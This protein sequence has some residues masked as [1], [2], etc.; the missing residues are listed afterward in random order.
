MTDDEIRD[1]ADANYYET[2][3]H[4]AL[5]GGGETYERDGIF[6]VASV[7]P[8]TMF[9]QAFVTR[10]LDDPRRALGDAIAFFD[11]R[12]LPFAIRVREGVDP[13]AERAC[14]ELGVPYSDTVP[15]MVLTDLARA[16]RT[17]DGLEIRTVASMTDLQH[18]I[19]ILVEAF[20]IPAALAEGLFAARILSL[21]DVEL[22]VGYV[23]GKPV[24]TSALAASTRVAGVYNVATVAA[25]RGRGI[26]EAMTA[27][28]VRRGA[29]SGC[30]ISSLQAT[31]MGRPVYERMGFTLMCPYR[32]F[33]RPGM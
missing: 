8:V 19:A 24:A 15:G 16:N 11:A 22:Y 2:S 20:G 27:H 30:V 9:N 29:S 18:H 13:A 12:N 7:I 28:A 23:D 1:R 33:H 3:K 32:T 4:Y 31:E 25:Q 10:P 5:I 6:A 17:V 14:E 26:G 21:L